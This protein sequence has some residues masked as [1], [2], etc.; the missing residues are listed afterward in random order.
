MYGGK[1]KKPKQRIGI[2]LSASACAVLFFIGIWF[3]AQWQFEQSDAY[4][5][6]CSYL[7]ET[8]EIVSTYGML[9]KEGWF[10]SGILMGNEAQFCFNTK[11]EHRVLISLVRGD[12][13]SPYIVVACK[14]TR[15]SDHN[16]NAAD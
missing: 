12:S 8:E 3:G 11:N 1:M 5:A 6:A 9:E 15:T 4:A 14:I 16:G 2:I 7:N 13:H 10:V